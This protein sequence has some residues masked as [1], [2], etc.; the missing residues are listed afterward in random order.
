MMENIP[1][2]MREKVTQIQESQSANQEEPKEAHCKTH[3]KQNGK[4]PRQREDL[5]GS[6]GEIGS[7]TQGSPDKASS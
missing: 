2:L 3:H 4:I 1:N 5:K 6:K 7:N